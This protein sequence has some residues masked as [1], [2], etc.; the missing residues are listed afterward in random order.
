MNSNAMKFTYD[1][2]KYFS[3]LVQTWSIAIQHRSGCQNLPSY[4]HPFLFVRH[5]KFN[6]AAYSYN[7]LVWHEGNT[8]IRM[9]KK[10]K[11]KCLRTSC[12]KPC[13]YAGK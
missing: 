4:A 7:T 8:M 5:T 12:L 13:V 3:A 11:N 1:K 10:K 9:G 6:D 2:A